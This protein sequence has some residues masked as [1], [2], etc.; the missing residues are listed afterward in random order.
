GPVEPLP[1]ARGMV[2]GR[3]RVPLR[4]APHGPWPPALRLRIHT[5]ARDLRARGIFGG[6]TQFFL[7]FGIPVAF[8]A[9]FPATVLLG[10]TG[11]LAVSPVLAY[12]APLAG[13][14]V[15]GLAILVWKHELPQYQSAGP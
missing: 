10:R 13:A 1:A 12:L 7:T 9:Y 4:A 5:H 6:A 14:I 11:E 3:D 2:A 8:I 15:F